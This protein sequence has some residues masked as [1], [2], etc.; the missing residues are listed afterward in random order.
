MA[1]INQGITG[2]FSGKVGTVVG[3]SWN[4]IDYMRSTGASRKDAQSKAQLEQRARFLTVVQFLNPLKEF[5]RI[6]FKSGA[7]NMSA[8]NAATSYHLEHSVTGTFPDYGIDYSRASVSRGKLPGVL[9]PAAVSGQAATIGFS[10]EDNSTAYDAKAD[11]RAVVVI[12]N[13]VRQSALSFTKG[14]TR[15]A[16]CQNITLPTS[17]SGDEV[18]CYIAFQNAGQTV[19]SDSR[20]VCSLIVL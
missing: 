12:Y 15:L 4:G 1:R 6:G 20:F 16:G 7:V 17:F 2:G 5:L 13:P 8:Y 18:H 11:D 3:G 9:S 10:W 14:C 19:I